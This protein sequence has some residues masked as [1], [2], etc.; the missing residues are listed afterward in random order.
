MDPRLAS[1]QV[2]QD[3]HEARMDSFEKK[4]E[5]GFRD[6]HTKIDSG[7]EGIRALIESKDRE[8]RQT[9]Q[10]YAE[11]ETQQ[12]RWKQGQIVAWAAVIGLLFVAVAGWIGSYFSTALQVEH[13]RGDANRRVYEV[14][15]EDDAKLQSMLHQAITN[16]QASGEEDRRELRDRIIAVEH[17]VQQVSKDSAWRADASAHEAERIWQALSILWEEV[18]K[19]PLP[20]PK[21]L[22]HG[23][24]RSDTLDSRSQ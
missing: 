20:Q 2:R 13:E 10:Q 11:A 18:R 6:V 8:G 4:V 14:Q 16:R 9:I 12:N 22:E 5:A 17:D 23:P 24:A 7:F 19:S 15:R 1:L 21:S 3:A